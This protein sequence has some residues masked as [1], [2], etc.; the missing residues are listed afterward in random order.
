MGF[1][2]YQHNGNQTTEAKV[3]DENHKLI[4]TAHLTFNGLYW[5]LKPQICPF[6]DAI[7]RALDSHN[8]YF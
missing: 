8:I 3:Y 6:K 4:A 2:E 5:E 7:L 1:I